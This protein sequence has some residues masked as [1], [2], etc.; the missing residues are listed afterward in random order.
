[1]PEQDRAVSPV[2]STILM[3]AIVVILSATIS[4][5]VLGLGEDIQNPS[6]VVGQSTGNIDP[7]SGG[8]G[9]I[10]TVTHIAGDSVEIKNV[11][12]IIDATDACNAKA[13]V[14]N[15]PADYQYSQF[16]DGVHF[17][18]FPTDVISRIE[19]PN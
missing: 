1:M 13:R 14:V 8:N 5:F 12:I 9:G 2:I 19:S 4:V 17:R 3:V 6:P 7:N 18:Y 11:Q 16:D 10:I 15:L